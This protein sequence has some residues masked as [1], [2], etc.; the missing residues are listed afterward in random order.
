MATQISFEETL[1]NS[2]L[3]RFSDGGSFRVKSLINGIMVVEPLTCYTI[4]SWAEKIASCFDEGSNFKGIKAIEFEFNGAYVSVTAKNATPDKI[5]QLYSKKCEENR[6]KWEKEYA[7]YQ[8][9]PEYRSKRAKE[10]K[11]STRREK[12]EQEVIHV[13]ETTELEFKDEEAAQKW[14]EWEKACTTKYSNAIIIYARRWAKYM[15]HII[16]KHNKSVFQIAKSTSLACNLNGLTS[17]RF[18]G[19]ISIL[20]QCWKYGADLNLWHHNK[21]LS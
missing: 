1:D 20:C 8:K 9:T 18:E 3:F 10:L 15:Q 7:E 6:I 17:Y 4:H 12:V 16:K 11:I 2:L 19:A 21:S 14:S 5:I 13:D